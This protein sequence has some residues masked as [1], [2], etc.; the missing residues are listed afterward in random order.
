MISADGEE[1]GT[2]LEKTEVITG[3]DSSEIEMDGQWQ[4]AARVVRKALVESGVRAREITGVG[5]CGHG[6]GIYPVTASGVPVC[7]ALTSMDARSA[8]TV[9]RWQREGISSYQKSR[10]HP[11]PGQS[12]PQLAW[13]KAARP[14]AFKSARWVLSAK[15]WVAFRLT[16]VLSA[17]RTDAS[18]SGFVNLLSGG[19]DAGMLE[20]FGLP[21]AFEKLPPLRDSTEIIGE[22]T[23]QAAEETGLSA[24]TPVIAGMLDVM[25]CALGSGVHDAGKYSLIA[26]TWNINTAFEGRLLPAPPSVK[27]SLGAD[28]RQIAYVESS[29]TSAGNLEWFVDSVIMP[30]AGGLSRAE[31][32]DAVNEGV[33]KLNAAQSSVLYFPFLYRSHLAQSMDA[34]FLGIRAGHGVHHLLGAIMEGAVFAHRRHLDILAASGLRRAAAVLSG[35]AAASPVW[36]RMFADITGLS[37][38][39]AR[40][41][42]AGA[43]GAAIAAAAGT[44]AYRSLSA[45]A[46]AMVKP[47]ARYDPDPHMRDVYEEKYREFS[48]IIDVMEASAPRAR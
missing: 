25:A 20:V 36:C 23:S 45:A 6:G 4:R 11:W 35:G 33:Q 19:Y 41:S 9:A 1:L 24:G 26:G 13:L 48:R 44:G 14:Q 5:V 29:A 15:S 22:V 17:D 42:Q 43:L 37:I 34:A 39:T 16:G 46:L 10:H 3:S 30:F 18:N 47:A 2:G 31:I 32:Y 8:E 28:G 38:E 27:C 40:T 21:D 12:L 7:K